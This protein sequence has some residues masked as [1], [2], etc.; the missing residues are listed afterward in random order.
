M[1]SANINTI[2]ANKEKASNDNEAGGIN[3][4]W[5][6]STILRT[7]PWFIACAIVAYLIAQIYL[8]YTIPVFRVGNE[9]LIDD[10][11]GNGSSSAQTAILKDLGYN[12]S[13]GDN[14]NNVMR[15]FR[16]R[17]LM[18]EVVEKLKLGVRYYEFGRFKTTEFYKN[19]PFILN[20]DDN[21][22]DNM[23]GSYTYVVKFSKDGSIEYKPKGD[24][25][26][27][28]TSLNQKIDLGFGLAYF[29]KTGY[30]M[31]YGSEYEVTVV[32]NADA[33]DLFSGAIDLARTDVSDNTV[34]ITATDV[35][36]ERGVD[37]VNTLVDVYK[38]YDTSQ[39][40]HNG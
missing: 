14:I 7:W 30:Q 17:E 32:N 16:K 29:I 38:R 12:T 3:L 13:Q 5:L 33:A 9:I 35:L 6:F 4:K 37:V 21:V 40:K 15:T 22:L 34:N 2:T 18:K 26:N 11:K 20:I 8:R 36:P 10:N 25:K 31:H 1:D 28:K 39:K 27:K 19:S 24:E 23:R